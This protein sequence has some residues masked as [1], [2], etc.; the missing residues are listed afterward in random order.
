MRSWT[1]AAFVALLAACGGGGA[2]DE[3]AHA[4]AFV[5][6]LQIA[7]TGEDT[8]VV[9]WRSQEP[10]VGV[11]ECSSGQRLT[12][13]EPTTEHVFTL[14]GLAASTDYEFAIEQDGG[15]VS[16][17]HRLG[18]APPAGTGSVRFVVV[19][20]SGA[21]TVAQRDVASNM[22]LS[23]P[24]LVLM[25]GDVVYESGADYEIDRAYFTPYAALLERV[26]FYP[27]VGNHDVV[28]DLGESFLNRVYLPRNSADGTERYYSFDRATVHFVALD[29]TQDLSPGSPQGDWFASDLA[30]NQRAWTIVYLHHPAYSS[31]NHGSDLAVRAALVP[32]CERC[33]VDVVFAGHDHVYERTHPLAGDVVVDADAGGDYVDPEGTVF[34]VTGG[35]GKSLYTAGTS[36]FTATSVSA[37]HHVVVEIAGNVLTLHA[38]DRNN[39]A[40]DSMTITRAR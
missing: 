10:V 13:A 39:L 31:S 34:V 8:V 3:P 22:A 29:S 1:V 40:L 5:R 26:P 30:A 7:Q 27:A 35:G 15:V 11:I 18:T 32:V 20:D 38:I 37:Y 17:G 4:A 33:G 2:S 14:T 36:E 6:G 16:G 19:G 12:G 24:D 28:S 25:T 9:A 23:N 21:G